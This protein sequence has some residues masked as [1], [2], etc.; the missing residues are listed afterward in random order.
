MGLRHLETDIRATS[1]GVIVCIHDSTVDRTTDGVGDVSSYTFEE[2]QNLDAGYRHATSNGYEFRG[3][4]SR[5]SSLEEVLNMFPDISLVVDMK[6]DGLTEAFTDVIERT[7]SHD[8][9]IVGSF[10]DRR[11]ELFREATSGKVATSTGPTLTR[12]WVLA[13]RVGRGGGG[14]ASALQVPTMIRG[15]RVVDEK[16]I[17]AAHNA[18]M[19]VHVWTVNDPDEMARLL[20]IGVDGL[21]TDRP[22]LLKKLLEERDEWV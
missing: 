14:E 8:R 21:V 3:N 19:Q 16:L 4:G 22:D 17:D 5:V 12:M 1:D 6:E 18:G 9:L 2:L 13:S 15:V 20:D 7:N 10:S 11:I